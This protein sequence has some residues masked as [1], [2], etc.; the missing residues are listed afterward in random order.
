MRRELAKLMSSSVV[1]AC[2]LVALALALFVPA[3]GAS[4]YAHAEAFRVQPA[5]EMMQRGDYIVVRL[6]E[7]AYLRKP[8]GMPWA[9]ALSTWLFGPGEFASRLV[10]AVATSL[11]GLIVFAFAQRWFGKPYGLIAGLAYILAPAL[12]W[13]PP[14]ARSAEIEALLNVFVASGAL[15]IVQLLVGRVYTSGDSRP[16]PRTLLLGAALTLALT[17]ALLTKGPAGVPVFIGAAVAGWSLRRRDT[18]FATSSLRE[19]FVLILAALIATT[20]LA[21]WAWLAHARVRAAGE[22]VVLES[23]TMFLFQPQRVLEIITLPVVVIAAMLPTSLGVLAV[24]MYHRGVPTAPATRAPTRMAQA[25]TL[26]AAISVL[27]F[28]LA[29]IGNNRYV[30]PIIP[31]LAAACAA[32]AWVL[33]QRARGFDIAARAREMMRLKRFAAVTVTLLIAAA[34]FSAWYGEHRRNVR[35]SGKAFG[36][37]LGAALTH[38]AELWADQVIDT[39]PEVIMAAV[40]V[41]KSHGI[42]IRPRWMPIALWRDTHGPTSVPLPPPGSYIIL[43]TDDLPRRDQYELD[44]EHEYAPI[45]PHL[46]EVH[47]GMVH[48]FEYRVYEVT[49][50]D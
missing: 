45:L 9:V 42:T 19:W 39:R 38:D 44:E 17:G 10:S 18:R 11:G 24:A 16:W 48:N 21:G 3:L 14:I 32:G 47:R 8:P 41:A 31:V 29:G 5:Y 25:L 27:V 20:A 33:V 37:E 12:W 46:Y 6:F 50:S 1:H 36:Q 35:T 13:Y 28:M 22:S 23:P 2:V 43:R 34:I 40:D 15:L 30:V 4:G 49:I 26:T 7:Q